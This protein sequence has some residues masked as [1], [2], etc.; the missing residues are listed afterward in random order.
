MIIV[1]GK[2]F[3]KARNSLHCGEAIAAKKNLSVQQF[4]FRKKKFLKILFI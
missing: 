3:I 1:V 2:T 4:R